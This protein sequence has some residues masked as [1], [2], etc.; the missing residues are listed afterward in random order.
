[1]T[2]LTRSIKL[3]LI[4]LWTSTNHLHKAITSK[5]NLKNLDTINK[6][7]AEKVM[8]DWVKQTKESKIP[9]LMKMAATIMAHRRG[10]PPW[11]GCHISTGKVEDINNKIKVIKRTAYGFKNERYFKLRLYPLHDSRITRNVG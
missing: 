2:S 7:E 11:Y 5:S 10:I 6:D 3:G 8:N 4:T 9:Q 1:M